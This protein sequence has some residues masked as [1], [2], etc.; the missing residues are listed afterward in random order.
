MQEPHTHSH[1]EHVQDAHT[2]SHGEHMQDAHTHSHEGHV[3]GHS[4]ASMGEI[5]HMIVHLEL[6]EAVKQDAIQVYQLI[7]EA[8]SHVHDKS[9]EEIHFHEVGTMDAVADIVGVCYLIH[10]LNAGQI[11]T[12][13]IHVGSGQ[14]HCAHG[15]L[16]VPAP[17][18]AYILRGVPVY[19]GEIRGELC[20]PTGAALLKHFSASFG[21]MPVMRIEKIGYGMGRKDFEA[22]NCVRVMLGE[23]MP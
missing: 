13:P 14:V 7:A 16:P 15:I 9:I 12:S 20:T 21:S 11:V 6:P 23:D 5:T 19:S 22:A 8:E 3:H 17:A 18:T 1:G 10:E 4:H 2:H